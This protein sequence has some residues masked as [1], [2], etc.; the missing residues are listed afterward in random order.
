MTITCVDFKN[1]TH[2]C[3]VCKYNCELDCILCDTCQNWFHYRCV[4][5]SKTKFQNLAS[6]ESAYSCTLCKRNSK[7]EKCCKTTDM[8]LLPYTASMAK[9]TYVTHERHCQL[10][11]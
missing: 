1:S 10:K 11:I 8:S 6:D 5:L 4:S 9:K 2:P 7:C 3:P